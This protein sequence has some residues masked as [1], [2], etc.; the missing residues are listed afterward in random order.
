VVVLAAD[1]G[2]LADGAPDDVLREQGASLAAAGVWAPGREPA[3]PLRVPAAPVPLVRAEGLAVGR[4]RG[5]TVAGDIGVGLSGGRITALTGPNGGGKSTLALTLGGLLPPVAGRVLAEPRLA[6]GLAEDPAAWRSREL[7]ARIGTV[8]QDP[9]H[10]FLAATVRAELEVGPRAVGMDPAES[11]RRVDELL[12]RLRLDGLA[13]ANPFTLS[14]GEKR[15][16]S[17][18]TALAT[19]P[20]LLVLDEPTFGQDARTWAE[21]VALLADLVDREGVGVLA[22]T[23]DADLVRA[24]ADDVL[25]LDPVPGGAA[26][27]EVVR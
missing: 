14:G 1:G 6:D 12:A 4:G 20:R 13:R 18:A 27:L 22:V 19:A 2:I 17:V 10:Q 23:H 26:R 24:L 25:R 11:A 21:L 9:E 16:L 8:F 7:A 3:A 15:R 5:A